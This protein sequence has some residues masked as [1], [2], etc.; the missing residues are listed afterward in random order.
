MAIRLEHRTSFDE[1][2]HTI[3]INGNNTQ[4]SK[5]YSVC[6]NPYDLNANWTY[7]N[8]EYHVSGQNNGKDIVDFEACAKLIKEKVIP[9][10]QPKPE[11]LKQLA[12]WNNFFFLETT[13]ETVGSIHEHA[14]KECNT[15]TLHGNRPFHC[16]K[17]VYIWKLLS[18]GIGLP[19]EYTL[20]NPPPISGHNVSWTLGCALNL[21]NYVKFLN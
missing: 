8:V 9:E 1:A 6:V 15:P 7:Q 14:K 5:L 12:V 10:I 21:L 4:G 2:H 19:E 17:M 3:L 18:D 16:L 13:V 11:T 20:Q